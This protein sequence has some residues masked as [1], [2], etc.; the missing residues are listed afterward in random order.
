MS[1]KGSERFPGEAP[2]RPRFLLHKKAFQDDHGRRETAISAEVPPSP[3]G[4]WVSLPCECAAA[5]GDHV[6]QLIL[7]STI[8][9]PADVFHVMFRCVFLHPCMPAGASLN[10]HD[11]RT[12][13]P[14]LHAHSAR[15]VCPTERQ[16]TITGGGCHCCC[17]GCTE[18]TLS[19]S[20]QQH[21][22]RRRQQQPAS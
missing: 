22:G 5:A 21:V 20:V 17:R 2:C 6:D 13:I 19:Q 7:Q 18:Q 15:P 10:R 4:V 14:P 9:G 12:R 11:P 16:I 8:R 3:P 1:P